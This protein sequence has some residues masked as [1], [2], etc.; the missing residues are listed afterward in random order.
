[1]FA[2][3]CKLLKTASKKYNSAL[4]HKNQFFISNFIKRKFSNFFGSVDVNEL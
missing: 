1:M 2:V 4:F 3:K